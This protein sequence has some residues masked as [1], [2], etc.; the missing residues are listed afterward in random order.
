MATWMLPLF[1]R[2]LE[3]DSI[4]VKEGIAASLRILV[5]QTTL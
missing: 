1:G 3:P 4:E 2:V 5:M